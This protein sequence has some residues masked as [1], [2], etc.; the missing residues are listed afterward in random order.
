MERQLARLEM[1]PRG[2]AGERAARR[3]GRRRT[4]GPAS[5]GARSCAA[6]AV[7][8]PIVVTRPAQCG[9]AAAAKSAARKETKTRCLSQSAAHPDRGRPLTTPSTH[10]RRGGRPKVGQ[11]SDWYG[12]AARAALAT[13]GLKLIGCGQLSAPA[14]QVACALWTPIAASS[15]GMFVPTPSSAAGA[16]TEAP[17]EG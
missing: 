11:I 5:E 17:L 16:R 9:A 12:T 10:H 7:P 13:A 6:L 8:M 4:L 3:S 2:R 1:S 15:S 14:R